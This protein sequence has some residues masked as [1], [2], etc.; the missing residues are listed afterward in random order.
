MNTLG[1]AIIV[2]AGLLTGSL[3]YAAG[4]AAAGEAKAAVCGGC[5]G[6]DGNSVAADFPKLAGQNE[7]YL[8]KQM[9]DIQGD[10]NGPRRPVPVMAAM[11][12]NLSQQDIEDMA[13]FYAAQTS[14]PGTA[15]EELVELGERLYRA[16]NRETGVAAC[17]ACH[18][19][20]G[21]GNAAAGF[22]RLSGQHPKYL[23]KQLTEYRNGTRN[24][25][26]DGRIMRDVARFLS[27]E[28]IRAVSSYASGLY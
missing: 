19:P 13:A 27:D 1:K 6:M 25:D 12:K 4:N 7:K 22:P 16:G 24:N 23:E 26:G 17:T 20:N 14:T 5:H 15:K 8:V 18:A 28:E 10:E 9:L 11:V 21:A 2:A 3:T